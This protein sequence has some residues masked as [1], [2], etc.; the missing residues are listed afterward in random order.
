VAQPVN[1]LLVFPSVLVGL[2]VAYV[3]FVRV[4]IADGLLSFPLL[5]ISLHH[6][7]A[8]R[9]TEV[10]TYG[11][12]LVTDFKLHRLARNESF[13]LANSESDV[14]DFVNFLKFLLKINSC[15]ITV[16]QGIGL[17]VKL[18]VPHLAL[19]VL[20]KL[21]LD[22]ITLAHALQLGVVQL[23]VIV[24]LTMYLIRKQL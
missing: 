23:Q 7:E 12:F 8:Y 4:V 16:H 18:H 20:L 10:N 21:F 6:L 17:L 5:H 22:D 24:K 19:A 15:H 14:L 11:H 13:L 1:H 3:A 9:L 2:H